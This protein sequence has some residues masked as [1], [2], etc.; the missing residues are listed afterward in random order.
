LLQ[1]GKGHGNLT[2]TPQREPRCKNITGQEG[3]GKAKKGAG[4]QS[5]EIEFKLRGGSNAKRTEK[6]GCQGAPRAKEKENPRCNG[7]HAWVPMNSG[8][9]TGNR[10][11]YVLLFWGIEGGGKK[12]I[13]GETTG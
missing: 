5:R 1:K 8:G 4:G 13:R 3:I 7:R 11:L 2:S 12:R 6:E 10:K 9:V